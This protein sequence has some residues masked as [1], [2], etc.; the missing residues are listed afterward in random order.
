[1]MASDEAPHCTK[2]TGWPMWDARAASKDHSKT[3]GTSSAKWK[4]LSRSA[5]SNAPGPSAAVI[6]SA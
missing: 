2:R 3:A 1:M 5:R 6:T 4:A